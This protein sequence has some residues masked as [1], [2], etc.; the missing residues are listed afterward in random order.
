MQTKAECS[1]LYHL[2]A[3]PL[4]PSLQEA[5]LTSVSD[6]WTEEGTQ[7]PGSAPVHT[8]QDTVS[9]PH[10]H[11]H[12]GLPAAT[13]LLPLQTC[14][15]PRLFPG[16]ISPQAQT[17][18]GPSEWQPCPWAIYWP[19]PQIWCH[20]GSVIANRFFG[21]IPLLFYPTYSYWK[22]HP[23]HGFP[24]CLSI[25]KTPFTVKI[26]CVTHILQD[27]EWNKLQNSL[28][29]LPSWGRKPAFYMLPLCPIQPE[30]KKKIGCRLT[31][32]FLSIPLSLW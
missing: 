13:K 5:R 9:H 31:K 2:W 27:H 18:L 16:V 24:Y 15:L 3:L 10:C 4:G 20:L 21:H 7:F 26:L 12:A 17:C 25:Q 28:T 32:D 30:L 29:L 8:A 22:L 23:D 6:F 14:S 19:G 1:K 11:A